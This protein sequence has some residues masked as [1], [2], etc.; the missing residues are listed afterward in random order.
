MAWLAGWEKRKSHTINQQAGA[1][2]NYQM[3]VTVH[4][5]GGVDAGEHI[6]CGGNCQNDFGDIRFTAS[7]GQTLLDYWM[8]SLTAGNQA[9][10]WVEI[11]D[12]LSAGNVTIYVYYDTAGA[13]VT[14]SDFDNTF[15]F[16]DP[17][18]NATLNATRWTSVDGNPVYS[19]NIVNHYLEITDMDAVE[20]QTGKGFHSKT[21]TFPAQYII[22]DA[23]SSSG[24]KQTIIPIIANN[25]FGGVFSVEDDALWGPWADLG[26]AWHWQGDHWAAN[27]NLRYYAGVGG[28][29]DWDSGTQT[30]TCGVAHEDLIR[31]WKLSG[32]INIEE[33]GVVRVNEANAET[34]D[35]V[36]LGISRYS[37]YT[38]GTLRFYAFIIRKYTSPEPV[39]G[40][41]GEEEG[42]P[43]A[44]P[45]DL[46]ACCE[47]V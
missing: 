46:Q 8:Q 17:F 20:H 37:S 44:D 45:T 32:N 10:F 38:F 28:N 22:Q 21:F 47:C 5:G 31:I 23:Y 4:K 12:D 9:T 7:D 27:C 36:H 42:L 30:H 15:I 26:I 39:H 25:C 18:D 35:R 40:G 13:S 43:P 16:G 29:M 33:D 14:T 34:P 1:G 2:T 41:W 11:S 19:I 24:F 6:Y 3:H